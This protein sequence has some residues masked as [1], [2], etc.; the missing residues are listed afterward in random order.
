MNYHLG[1]A[2]AKLARLKTA[3]WWTCS[4]RLLL[5]L[6]F[7]NI[8]LSSSRRNRFQMVSIQ[9]H[10]SC[11]RM[12]RPVLTV[13]DPSTPEC[14]LA[15]NSCALTRLPNVDKFTNFVASCGLCYARQLSGFLLF[16]FC[17]FL[18]VFLCL[19]S[20]CVGLCVVLKAS[21]LLTLANH[22]FKLLGNVALW[23]IFL[24]SCKGRPV[25][26]KKNRDTLLMHC[27]HEN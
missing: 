7:C 2:E 16:F 1:L 3:N 13:N 6:P 18:V 26:T 11:D 17:F 15:S 23:N 5:V 25:N 22:I 24:E 4:H 12:L 19:V 8:A 27:L 14:K 21:Y 20:V 9:T 10:G